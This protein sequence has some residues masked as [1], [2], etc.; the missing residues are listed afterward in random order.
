MSR[1]CACIAFVPQPKTQASDAA[2]AQSSVAGVSEEITVE[3]TVREYRQLE[4][5]SAALKRLKH[6][7]SEISHD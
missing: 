2:P 5:D 7:R 1:D 6:I 3:I 4:A